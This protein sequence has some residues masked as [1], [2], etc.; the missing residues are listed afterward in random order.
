MNSCNGYSIVNQQGIEM[1]RIN[2]EDSIW[3]DYRF[4]TLCSKMK[5]ADEALG[6]IIRSWILAQKWYLKNDRM[7][8]M[9]EW[10]KQQLSPLLFEVGLAM[11]VDETWVKVEWA[12]DQFSWLLQRSAAGKK[13][14][15]KTQA[16]NQSESS[17][18]LIPTSTAKANDNGIKPLPLPLP[19][20]LPHSQK[21]KNTYVGIRVDYPQEFNALWESYGKRGDKKSAFEVYKKLNL[22]ITEL[23]LLQT[24]VSNYISQTEPKYRKHLCRFLQTDFR[25]IEKFDS[26][27]TH[28]PM[29]R[30][31]EEILADQA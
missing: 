18:R 24:A 10:E 6:A 22:S 2:V 23:E 5:N 31:I 16:K 15:L 19:H 20:S 25:E 4:I 14:G 30:G 27:V 28:L 12:D 11:I 29:R 9:K 3:S 1:A 17:D 21:K 8:P 13:G 7:I 26:N